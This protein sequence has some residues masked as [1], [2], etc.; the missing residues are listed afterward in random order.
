MG[1][2]WRSSFYFQQRALSLRL[3]MRASQL[4][5]AA[6]TGAPRSDS[7]EGHWQLRRNSGS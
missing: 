2:T 7:D 5:K 4:G 3:R 1:L 6:T